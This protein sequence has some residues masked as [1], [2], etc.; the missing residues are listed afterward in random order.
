[1][2]TN[3]VN[4]RNVENRRKQFHTCVLKVVGKEKIARIDILDWILK[5]TALDILSK[6]TTSVE[7]KRVK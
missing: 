3:Q 6:Y 1:M 5:E 7:D 4:G 2:K